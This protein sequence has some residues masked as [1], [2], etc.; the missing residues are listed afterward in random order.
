M[1]KVTSS[2][3]STEHWSTAAA[4]GLQTPSLG[5]RRRRYESGGEAPVHGNTAG[6][7]QLA[8]S[9]PGGGSTVGTG[10]V[11]VGLGLG[12]GGGRWVHPQY[13]SALL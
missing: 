6:L 2:F 5:R 3:Y 10:G 1:P 7:L 12:L 13:P 11:V 4:E 8:T 9:K